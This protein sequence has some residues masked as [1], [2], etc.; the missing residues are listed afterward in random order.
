[1]EPTTDNRKTFRLDTAAAESLAT[2]KR[3]HGTEN[4]AIN[5][6]LVAWPKRI[7]QQ[8]QLI[9]KLREEIRA[10]ENTGREWKGKAVEAIAELQK[11]KNA[12]A[13]VGKF[14]NPAE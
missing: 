11:V 8:E 12:L 9:G 1:M 10:A 6:V 3:N 14:L 7:E 2:A 13:L 4:A 5:H